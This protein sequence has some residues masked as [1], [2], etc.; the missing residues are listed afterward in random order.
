MSNSAKIIIVLTVITLFSGG[1]LAL[2]DNFTAPK[3]KAHQEEVK[4]RALRAALPDND[5]VQELTKGDYR[6][7]AAYRD[8]EIVALAFEAS[9]GGYQSELR[10]MVGVT[11]DFNTITGAVILEQVETPGL[12]TKI[13][14]DPANKENPGWFMG[15]FTGLRTEPE[16]S[17]VKNE[18]PGNDHEVRAI[19]GATISSKAVV[20]ILNEH[21]KKAEAAWNE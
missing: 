8:N 6:F 17:Y 12:G 5:R 9:G 3:I 20:N 13:Q 14:E 4:N 2:L 7:Y 10:L 21:I 16:I 11:P 1:V 18:E 19:T 15:Q